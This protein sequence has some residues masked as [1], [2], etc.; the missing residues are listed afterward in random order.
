M[1]RKSRANAGTPEREGSGLE[2]DLSNRI[3]ELPANL[4][5]KCGFVF[6]MGS[7]SGST[8]EPPSLG[9]AGGFLVGD[10]KKSVRPGKD[11]RARRYFQPGCIIVGHMREILALNM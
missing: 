1:R 5:I 11:C 6:A 7:P 9:F 10:R 8:K 3:P 2:R 4:L